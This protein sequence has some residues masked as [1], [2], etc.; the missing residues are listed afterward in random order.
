MHADY[1]LSKTSVVSFGL[2]F[3]VSKSGTNTYFIV[4]AFKQALA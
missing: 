2:G 1:V 4:A 3:L